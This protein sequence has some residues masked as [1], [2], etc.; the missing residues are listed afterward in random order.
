MTASIVC[1]RSNGTQYHSDSPDNEKESRMVLSTSKASSTST[2]AA[3]STGQR[4]VRKSLFLSFLSV[5]SSRS[6]N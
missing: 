4:V 5:S 2:N 1:S 6:Q 3:K